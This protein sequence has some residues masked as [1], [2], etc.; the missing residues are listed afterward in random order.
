ME[1]VI[2]CYHKVGPIAEEGR[3]LNVEAPRLASHLRHYARKKAPFLVASAF[4][5]RPYPSGVC[6]T[7][8]DAYASTLLNAP[9][10]LERFGALGTFY[11]VWSKLGGSSDWD[12]PDDR[13]LATLEDLRAAARQGHEIGNHTLS[14]RRLSDLSQTDQ[15]TEI[16]AAHLGLVEAGLAP[17]TICYPYGGYDAFSIELAKRTGYRVG[18]SLKKGL[19]HPDSDPLAL[20]RIVVACSDTVPMLVYKTRI[21]HRLRR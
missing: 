2:L 20:P 6:L 8:D 13:P 17:K 11:V 16:E 3:R 21:R 18:V 19:V 4:S 9:P 14:H 12:A 10:V 15:R 5:L 1:P 7:F